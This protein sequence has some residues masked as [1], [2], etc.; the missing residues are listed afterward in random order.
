MHM[1]PASRDTHLSEIRAFDLVMLYEKSFRMGNK[2]AQWDLSE[3]G[4]KTGM[5][6]FLPI[7]LH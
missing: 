3:M 7:S 6:M 4:W 5:E 2:P 1:S